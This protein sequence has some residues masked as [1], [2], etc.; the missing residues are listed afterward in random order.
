MGTETAFTVLSSL[1]SL[2]GIA[3]LLFWRYRSLCTDWFRQRVFELRDELFNYAADGKI[4][5]DDPAYG[6]LRQTMNGY[7]RFAHQTTGWHGLVFAVFFRKADRQYMQQSVEENWSKA[8]GA[9]SPDARQHIESL[10]D[11]LETVGAVHLLLSAPELTLLLLPFVLILLLLAIIVG[12]L[13]RIGLFVTDSPIA[14]WTQS[15]KKR[16]RL[17]DDVAMLY[18]A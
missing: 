11:K 6:M 17:A 14:Q 5:F 7:I 18:G 16:L 3:Y 10:R 4:N 2:V 9:L 12:V 13:M 1:L 8:V 15:L